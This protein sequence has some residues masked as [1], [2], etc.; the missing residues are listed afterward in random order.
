MGIALIRIKLMPS[1]P[2]AD[3]ESIKEEARKI[4]ESNKGNKV[5]FEEEAIAF[6]LKAI[7]VG[8]EQNEEEGELDSIESA[9]NNIENVS[10]VQIVDMRRAFG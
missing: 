6:G 4:V 3:L 1:S 2:E 8:F 5:S 9:F 10:S 7:I